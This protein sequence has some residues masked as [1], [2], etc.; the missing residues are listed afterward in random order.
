MRDDGIKMMFVSEE[1]WISLVEWWFFGQKKDKNVLR[2][3]ETRLE[4][5]Y[6]EFIILLF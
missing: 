2:Q 3:K 1:S 4:P 6:F 5:Q